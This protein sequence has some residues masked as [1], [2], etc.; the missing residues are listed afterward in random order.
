[1]SSRRTRG[2]LCYGSVGT[3]QRRVVHKIK[4]PRERTDITRRIEP[5]D[6]VLRT[7]VSVAP[8]RF[9]DFVASHYDL[10]GR[11]SAPPRTQ[12]SASSTIAAS[13]H[14][15][16]AVAFSPYGAQNQ[17]PTTLD[18]WLYQ[19]GIDAACVVLGDMMETVGAEDASD[20]SIASGHDGREFAGGARPCRDRPF[21]VL[22]DRQKPCAL[23]RP[24][25]RSQAGS[26]ADRRWAAATGARRRDRASRA[27]RHW[28]RDAA[29]KR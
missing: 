6:R 4:N 21:Q 8:R 2:P 3:A 12:R 29:K 20:R 11:R 9:T 1:M 25:P 14:V 22:P 27:R 10:A 28:R 23:C 5:H 16:D 26:A 18:D 13:N 24:A 15:A 7:P 17:P 19:A